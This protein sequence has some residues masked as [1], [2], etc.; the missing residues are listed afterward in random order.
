MRAFCKGTGAAGVS[1]DSFSSGRAAARNPLPALLLARRH[2]A[3]VLSCVLTVVEDVLLG[4]SKQRNSRPRGETRVR[5][6]AIRRGEPRPTA[7]AQER[8]PS[9]S[10]ARR[11]RASL[12]RI[13]RTQTAKAPTPSSKRHALAPDA[14][15]RLVGERVEPVLR[16]RDEKKVRAPLS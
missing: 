11:H 12:A 13:V 9:A 7:L 8:A 3:T 6:A 4:R 16:A 5:P 2:R 1:V 14:R 10:R 15:P